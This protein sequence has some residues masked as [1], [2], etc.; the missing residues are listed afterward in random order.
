MK[1]NLKNNLKNKDVKLIWVDSNAAS[2]WREITEDYKAAACVVES[3]GRVIYE[4]YDVI[5]LACSYATSFIGNDLPQVNG[6]IVIPKV[7]IKETIIF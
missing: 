7:C 6:T 3:V 1:N 2:G 4:D 5:E